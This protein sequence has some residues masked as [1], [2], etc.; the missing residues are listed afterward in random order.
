MTT[1]LVVY[2]LIGLILIPNWLN[3]TSEISTT[4][5]NPSTLNP[6]YST[7][8]ASP[9]FLYDGTSKWEFYDVTG[10]FYYFTY[11]QLPPTKSYYHLVWLYCHSSSYN[12]NLYLYS[13]SSYSTG[14]GS[15][16][17]TSQ[18]DWIVYRISSAKNMYPKVTTITAVGSD[19][20]DVEYRS[21]WD[22]VVGIS[23]SIYLDMDSGDIFDIYEIELDSSKTYTVT[24]DVVAGCNQDIYVFRTA[25]ESSTKLDLQVGN[26]GGPGQDEVITFSP[27]ASDWYAIVILLRSDTDDSSTVN[28]SASGGGGGGDI[29]GFAMLSVLLTL[30][31][32]I[33]LFMNLNKKR[34]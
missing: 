10:P 30:A 28:V 23:Y 31:V 8:P 7:N 29:P 13:D 5:N 20:V 15:S 22:M 32:T 21:A 17:S 14:V 26:S 4:L 24:L 16:T 1:F 27:T 3:P 6:T 2:F 19:E 12:Y 25:A 11:F 18:W 33:Y 9:V 34:A